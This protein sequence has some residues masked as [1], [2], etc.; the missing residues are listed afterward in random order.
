[1]TFVSPFHESPLCSETPLTWSTS[2]DPE[3]CT[4]HFTMTIKKPTVFLSIFPFLKSWVST[5]AA[6]TRFARQNHSNKVARVRFI[7]IIMLDG[8]IVEWTETHGWWAELQGAKNKIYTLGRA[9]NREAEG[10]EKYAGVFSAKWFNFLWGPFL[11][12]FIWTRTFFTRRYS[13]C[14]CSWFCFCFIFYFYNRICS[15]AE[16]VPESEF[17]VRQSVQIFSLP[18]WMYPT[19]THKHTD[20]FVAVTIETFFMLFYGLFAP[21]PP[22]PPQRGGTPHLSKNKQSKSVTRTATSGPPLSGF[23]I[24]TLRLDGEIGVPTASVPNRSRIDWRPLKRHI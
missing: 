24:S 3:K 7:E 14:W 23:S 18:V 1:M 10:E 22:F 21:V 20:K 5:F 17:S 2:R 13:F 12:N 16:L 11:V 8:R 4:E 9:L 6:I 15:Q 19:Q